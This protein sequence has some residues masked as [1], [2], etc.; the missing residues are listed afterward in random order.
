M[1]ENAA[2]ENLKIEPG[3]LAVIAR[4]AEAA[5]RAL[6]LLSRRG[7]LRDA[8]RTR[9]ARNC[10]GVVP[11][12][13]LGNWSARFRKDRRT[14]RWGWCTLPKGRRNLQHF[15]RE[16]IRQQQQSAD[17]VRL[18]AGRIGCDSAIPDQLIRDWRIETRIQPRRPDAIT[19]SAAWTDRFPAESV[20]GCPFLYGMV[21]QPQRAVRR[22]FRNR[23]D[24]FLQRIIRHHAQQFAHL[25][26]RNRIAA[27]AR[28][29]PKQHRASRNC[30]PPSARIHRQRARLDL[31][32]LSCRIFPNLAASPQRS[33]PRK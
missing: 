10:W 24:Q 3:A 28:A 30:L 17:R 5:A 20:A 19:D 14:A 27:I 32:I 9:G 7:L 12:D 15:C 11:D 2:R 21:H 1:E 31:Q 8:F 4:M 18:F 13:A 6:S 22:S 25:L 16:A 29:C 33:A 23:A 26:V